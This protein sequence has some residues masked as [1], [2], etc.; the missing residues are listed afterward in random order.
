MR[1]KVLWLGIGGER[2]PAWRSGAVGGWI[3]RT[4]KASLKVGA[5]VE[6]GHDHFG[7][8]LLG[9]VPW[10][11]GEL[12]GGGGFGEGRWNGRDGAKEA[13]GGLCAEGDFWEIDD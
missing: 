6:S 3:I 2:P 11:V 4:K 1:S 5:D 9:Q 7:E 8:K 12:S 10:V 13:R